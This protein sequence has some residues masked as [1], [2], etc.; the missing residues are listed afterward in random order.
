MKLRPESSPGGSEHDLLARNRRF[1]DLLWS[2]ARLIEPQQFNTWALVQSLLSASARRLEVAPGLRPRLPILGTQFVDISA[3]A[4]MKLQARGAQ[5]VL[6]QVT[7]LPFAAEAFELVC[8]LDIIEHVDDDDRAL[9]E[10]SR[11]AKPGGV[12]LVSMPLHPSLWTS[13]DDF[14]GHKRRYEPQQ[15]LA[16][17]TQHDL[18]VERSAAFGMQPRSSRLVDIGMWWLLHHRE[19]AM[20]WYNRAFM[21]LGL[22]FQKELQFAPGIIPTDSVDEILLVCRKTPCR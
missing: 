6:G 16:K 5:V 21:P 10:V 12:V 4:L 9:S 15:L 8:A 17:L 1:Y 7:S 20:W 13:F 22:R 11:V 3:P 14:V 18:Q 2:G 19:R